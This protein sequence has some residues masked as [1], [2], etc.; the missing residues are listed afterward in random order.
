MANPLSDL[1]NGVNSYRKH[2]VMGPWGDLNDETAAMSGPSR[3][4]PLG[5][6]QMNAINAARAQ[7]NQAAVNAGIGTGPNG[8]MI[9]IPIPGV[10][11][12]AAKGFTSNPQD[13]AAAG[14]QS[15]LQQAYNQAAIA[16]AAGG[17]GPGGVGVNNLLQQALT[18]QA[19]LTKQDQQSMTL[20]PPDRSIMT[21]RGVG[22]G[23]QRGMVNRWLIDPGQGQGMMQYRP[24]GP[25][26]MRTD[27]DG[28]QRDVGAQALTPTG[29]L[30][31]M[32]R[33]RDEV[34]DVRRNIANF[35]Q[36][37][38]ERDDTLSMLKD[39]LK[40]ATQPA[41]EGSEGAYA[42]LDPDHTPLQ[43][44]LIEARNKQIDPIVA[45]AGLAEQEKVA[46]GETK[47]ALRKQMD[48]IAATLPGSTGEV[49][50]QARR[51]SK[52]AELQEEAA[53]LLKK[54]ESLEWKNRH[55]F[56]SSG[57]VGAPPGIIPRKPTAEEIA[58]EQA[59]RLK[60]QSL[61]DYQK[62]LLQK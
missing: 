55:R 58:E 37:R 23:S 15:P 20:R 3:P 22:Q 26:P 17:V 29:K 25:T 16:A 7:A 57:G 41:K 46:T 44:S 30:W 31:S 48:E 42:P 28:T 52:P 59:M 62:S 13:I 27:P 12:S 39:A 34:A 5:A 56:A 45:L 33:G 51:E 61:L 2:P 32:R 1:L 24:G 21:M 4:V 54:L 50:R 53:S 19:P 40:A 49:V 43:R 47:Q 60:H 14:T 9:Q 38:G 8:E 6:T 10:S 11:P 36:K 18:P 35:R